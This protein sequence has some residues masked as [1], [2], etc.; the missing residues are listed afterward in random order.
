LAIFVGCQLN[1]TQYTILIT[2]TDNMDYSTANPVKII[3]KEDI[4]PLFS[5]LPAQTHKGD[6]GRLVIVGGSANYVGA[7]LLAEAGASAMRVGAGTNVLAVPSFLLQSLYARVTTSSLFALSDDGKSIIFKSEE[8]EELKNKTTAFAVGMGM[9]DG[10]ASQ[11]AR[12]LLDET[13]C[14]IVLDADGLKACLKIGDF[15]NRAVLTPHIGEF[16]RITG[17][18]VEEIEKNQA[19]LAA[20]FAKEKNCVLVLKSHNSIVTDGQSIYKNV[21]GNPRLAKGGSGDVLAGIIGGLLARGVSLLD[22]ACGG[23][24]ILGRCAEISQINE[25]AH[26]ATDTVSLI[27]KVLEEFKN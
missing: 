1:L 26:L 20:K 4:T 10:E 8:F 27:P 16:S 9:G 2:A 22:A 19:A 25:Y 7:P 24:Y 21:T 17:M 18:S 12:F 5:P 23:C 13:D 15:K 3:S 6:L 14:K 11:I